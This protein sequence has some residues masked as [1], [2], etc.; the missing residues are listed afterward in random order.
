MFPRRQHT[1]VVCR[2]GDLNKYQGCASD[3]LQRPP[4]SG[5]QP[6]LTPAAQH[7]T[8]LRERMEEISSGD[9]AG[10]NA[11]RRRDMMRT[12]VETERGACQLHDARYAKRLAHL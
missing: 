7:Y 6:H 4:R 9:N 8:P 3:G 1:T 5:F 2:G 12:W 11:T 10:S